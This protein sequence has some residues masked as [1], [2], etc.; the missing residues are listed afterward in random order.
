M[1]FGF[2]LDFFL[3]QLSLGQFIC[4]NHL[5]QMGLLYEASIIMYRIDLQGSVVCWKKWKTPDSQRSAQ[6]SVLGQSQ[7]L[8]WDLQDDRTQCSPTPVFWIRVLS[9][10]HCLSGPAC[11]ACPHL[12]GQGYLQEAWRSTHLRKVPTSEKARAQANSSIWY[13]LGFN[14]RGLPCYFSWLIYNGWVVL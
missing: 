14:L 3:V 6:P 11:P 2:F 5:L 10:A 1:D 8:I 9:S 4:W 12:K 13:M 7:Q